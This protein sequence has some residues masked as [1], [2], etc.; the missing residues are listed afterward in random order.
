MDIASGRG[1]AARAAGSYGCS[2]G[3]SSRSSRGARDIALALRRVPLLLA[4]PVAEKLRGQP[5]PLCRS[6][7][8][9]MPCCPREPAPSLSLAKAS[10][11]CRSAAP[12]LPFRLRVF[13]S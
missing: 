11:A 1:A 13:V 8:S 7:A 5:P 10:Y 4:M 2:G 12:S 6:P 9:A 3:G